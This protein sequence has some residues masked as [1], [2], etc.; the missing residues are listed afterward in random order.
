MS[1]LSVSTVER[2]EVPPLLE[3][4]VPLII[5]DM[6]LAFRLGFTNKT[7]WFFV[8][9][10]E[11]AYKAFKI[12]KAS[13]KLRQ[14]HAPTP[15]M[16]LLLT[17][18]RVRIL[19][20]LV[21]KLGA[22]VTA[23]RENQGA[24]DAVRKHVHACAICD[25]YDVQHTCE[26]GVTS[27]SGKYKVEK[28]GL[29][30]A[31]AQ[32]PKHEN[33]PR[34][35]VKVHLDLKDFFPSTRPAWIRDFFQR[36]VGYNAR[37]SALLAALMTV[38]IERTIRGEKK[39]LRGVP[40]GAPTSGDICNLVANRRLDAPLLQALEGTG[41]RYTRYADDLYFSHPENLPHDRVRALIEQV[42]VHALA[43]GWHLNR[44]KIQVQ[45]PRWQQ[46]HLGV[47]LNQKPNVPNAE[48]R[49]MRTIIHR[50]F[51]NGFDAE[52]ERLKQ[53]SGAKLASWILGKIAWFS[54]VN[55]AKAARLRA[56]YEAA[57]ERHNA[58]HDNA[59]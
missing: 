19:L 30:K 6:S 45:R 42:R 46:R 59:A 1:H 36:E 26:V 11:R 9:H 53:M 54:A 7:L 18:L 50:C 10:P 55:P 56:V 2:I 38:P 48:Y 12:K 16:K 44:E 58:R 52:A 21:R 31:C 22:H 32:P 33:C 28:R 5:D 14:I 49:R 41:W 29:C 39:T 24:R 57:K 47:S 20:P 8:R 35:G 51:Y 40:Q 4:G 3:E 34:R 37:V 23:Y 25:Q 13:G 17:L 27:N 43:A 15:G